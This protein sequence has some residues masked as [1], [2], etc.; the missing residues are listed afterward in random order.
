[1]SNGQKPVNALVCAYLEVVSAN[2]DEP[3]TVQGKDGAS[4]SYQ[5][6]FLGSEVENLIGITDAVKAGRKLRLYFVNTRT[7]FLLDGQVAFL[8]RLEWDG[9]GSVV[10][11]QEVVEVGSYSI[12][13]L[14]AGPALQ[15]R[16]YEMGVPTGYR[17]V[18]STVFTDNGGTRW[19]SPSWAGQLTLDVTIPA[20]EASEEKA[21]S[22]R[23]P[24]YA[25]QLAR[26][27]ADFKAVADAVAARNESCDRSS[28]KPAAKTH[29]G[30]VLAPVMLSEVL[31]E[32]TFF[33]K[34]VN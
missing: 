3:W 22:L 9:T 18:A 33:V 34:K 14:P 29:E 28:F 23:L 19:A 5:R 15:Q 32:T 12:E 21:H 20:T 4:E 27:K 17:P 2:F 16:I 25:S 7:T 31:P 8:R 11:S 10:L 6:A 26:V 24:I 1:M 13:A 30:L